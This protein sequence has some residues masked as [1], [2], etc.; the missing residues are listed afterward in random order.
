MHPRDPADLWDSK[1]TLP[2]DRVFLE[3]VVGCEGND[4]N[5]VI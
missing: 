1:H 2:A 3:S 5:D 4:L